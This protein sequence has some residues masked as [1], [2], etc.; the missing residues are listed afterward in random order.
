MPCTLKG[1]KLIYQQQKVPGI[2]YQITM[3][4]INCRAVVSGKGDV[5][6]ASVKHLQ[7]EVAYIIVNVL[8]L[9]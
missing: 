8:P 3:D 7:R 1:G 9:H 6:L 2:E 5:Y 4:E